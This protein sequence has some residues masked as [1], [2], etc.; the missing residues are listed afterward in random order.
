MQEI[1]QVGS[2][3]ASNYRSGSSTLANTNS[4]R[5]Q[6]LRK[7]APTK[8]GREYSNSNN[9]VANEMKIALKKEGLGNF[10]DLM[11]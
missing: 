6:M 1:K 7:S 5:R 10:I 9:P 3:S 2:N 8:K 4:S 11:A